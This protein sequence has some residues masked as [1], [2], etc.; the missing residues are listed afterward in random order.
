VKKWWCCRPWQ[1]KLLLRWGRLSDL[2]SSWQIWWVSV[3][4][5]MLVLLLRE[6]NAGGGCYGVRLWEERLV[7]SAAERG[8]WMAASTGNKEPLCGFRF[9]EPKI[10][11]AGWRPEMKRCYVR[12]L[13]AGA[14]RD[15]GEGM[16]LW[17]LSAENDGKWGKIGV[18]GAGEKELKRALIFFVWA[19]MEENLLRG[20]QYWSGGL[21]WE[22]DGCGGLGAGWREKIK[23]EGGQPFGL[24]G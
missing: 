11:M 14:E 17:V 5:L 13:L 6:G 7:L 15:S 19:K 18:V 20:K 22:G 10:P 8:K 21:L 12:G 2:H 1:L 24:F 4:V 16:W 23:T 3:L 9:W